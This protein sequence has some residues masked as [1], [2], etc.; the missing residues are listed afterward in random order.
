MG[1]RPRL[2]TESNA[3]GALAN[4]AIMPTLRTPAF[5]PLN[6]KLAPRTRAQIVRR[7]PNTD[8]SLAAARRSAARCRELV[9]RRSDEIVLLVLQ[10]SWCCRIIHSSWFFN[11][12]ISAFGASQYLCEIVT[13]EQLPLPTSSRSL[14]ASESEIPTAISF[15][16]HSFHPFSS[17]GAEV[18]RGAMALRSYLS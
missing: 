5:R 14:L 16:F 12:I 10:R 7:G 15:Y 18:K 6:A 9:V 3:R 1:V 17:R 8:M 4:V 2:R 11:W 13:I